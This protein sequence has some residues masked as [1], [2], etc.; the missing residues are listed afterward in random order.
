[1]WKTLRGAVSASADLGPSPGSS[2]VTD[3]S[4]GVKT[5][6]LRVLPLPSI[7]TSAFCLLP[8][9]VPVTVSTDP[10]GEAGR[11]TVHIEVY[12][13]ELCGKGVPVISS[14]PIHHYLSP[15]PDRP[16]SLGEGTWTPLRG[17]DILHSYSCLLTV[18]FTPAALLWVPFLTPSFSPAVF[19]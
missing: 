11:L 10:V 5:A 9:S 12:V 17:F 14:M 4:V 15:V 3:V 13:A 6:D 8:P 1:M 2:E 16:G 18:L 19:L 7:T